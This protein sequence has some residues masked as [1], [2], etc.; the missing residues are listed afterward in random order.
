[1]HD[2]VIRNGT[3]V[4]GTGRPRFT[5]DIAIDGS[6]ISAVGKVAARGPPRDRCQRIS[7]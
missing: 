6:T 5:G 7:S 3:V 2:L 1:M 4:D